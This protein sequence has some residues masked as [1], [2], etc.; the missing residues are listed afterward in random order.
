MRILA[1]SQDLM[2]G[3]NSRTSRCVRWLLERLALGGHDVDWLTTAATPNLALNAAGVRTLRPSLQLPLSHYHPVGNSLL[4]SFRLTDAAANHSE[5]DGTPDILLATD[6]AAALTAT[7]IAALYRRPLA[8]LH[9]AH[10]VAPATDGKHPG[11]TT[12]P[13]I[14]QDWSAGRADTVLCV[15]HH[16]LPRVRATLRGRRVMTVAPPA[17][18]ALLGAAAFNALDIRELFCRPEDSLVLLSGESLG[19]DAIHCALLAVRALL[20]R[21]RSVSLVISGQS[22]DL[23]LLEADAGSLLD[24]GRAHFCGGVSGEFLRALYEVADLV[25]APEDSTAAAWTA[26]DCLALDA[27]LV[28]APGALADF[29]PSWA[30]TPRVRAAPEGRV[31]PLIDAMEGMLYTTPPVTRLSTGA[32]RAA[33]ER[34]WQACVVAVERTLEDL[35]GARQE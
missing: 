28:C 10:A 24:P 26:A 20:R 13:S 11:W 7:Q 8:I 15:G 19:R 21:G 22:T 6:W 2:A 1:L 16:G 17:D 35:A 4:E 5:T 9:Q 31:E 27:P 18:P 32:R 3:V 25:I 33:L 30:A 34:S 12:F 14:L 29:L 23:A